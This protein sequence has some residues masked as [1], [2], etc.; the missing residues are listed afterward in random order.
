MP[1]LAN[2]DQGCAD[3]LNVTDTTIVTTG[4]AHTKTL[5][6]LTIY[7]NPVSNVLYISVDN[8]QV[9]KDNGAIKMVC[10]YTIT[11]T[12][13]QQI[14]ANTNKLTLNIT[15]IPNGMYMVKVFTA[16]GIAQVTK[17]LKE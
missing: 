14:D 7:P 17:L 1:V 3:T 12:I 5:E 9:I 10:L 4:I 2:E 13:V 16:D 6:K 15:S 11:G 8:D